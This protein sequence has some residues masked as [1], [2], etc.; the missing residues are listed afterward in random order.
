ML[1]INIITKQKVDI[2]NNFNWPINITK[3]KWYMINKKSKDKDYKNNVV[4]LKQK[5]NGNKINNYS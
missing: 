5:S 1:M 3:K 2:W 4:L